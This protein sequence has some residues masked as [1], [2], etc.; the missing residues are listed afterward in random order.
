MFV[1]REYCIII[2]SNNKLYNSF[3]YIIVANFDS[4]YV[5]QI[6]KSLLPVSH[7]PQKP[8][9]KRESH[10]SKKPHL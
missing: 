5:L 1:A 7:T 4:D 9:A 10:Q 6:T 8:I 2:Y 3:T